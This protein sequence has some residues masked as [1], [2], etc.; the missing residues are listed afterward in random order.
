MADGEAAPTG[1]GLT[2]GFAAQGVAGQ[3]G[4]FYALYDGADFAAPGRGLAAIIAQAHPDASQSEAAARDAAQL[5]VHS[6]AE[7]YFGAQRTLSPRRAAAVALTSLNRWLAGQ[8][9]GDVTRHPVPVSLSALLFQHR[10]V[11]IVQIGT[12]QI[13]RQRGGA[14]APLIRP[15]MRLG[16]GHHPARA[17]GLEDDLA[18]GFEEEEAEAGD[19]FLLLA[20]AGHPDQVYAAMSPLAELPDAGV[21][22]FAARALA[23]LPGP[24]KAVMALRVD[25]LP[26]AGESDVSAY[27]ADLAIRPPPKEGDIWDE[28]II[29]KTLFMGRYTVLKAATDQRTGKEVALKIPLKSMLQDEVFAAGFMREAW[30]G[31]T[32]R[33]ACVAHYID[34]PESRRTSL[35]LA[36]KLYHGQTLEARLNHAPPVSLPEGVG[37]ALKLC[38]AI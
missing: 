34:V 35:Y 1:W 33:S 32:V 27:L 18:V 10:R 37:I 8:M 30:I 28:F 17:L 11:I 23:M 12:C 13:F 25:A 15:H 14:L 7:G 21:E 4:S 6:F 3:C 22:A 38:E 36:M 5:A 16:P 19:V 29:G 9:Q 24:G 31:A 20:G 26:A 2:P